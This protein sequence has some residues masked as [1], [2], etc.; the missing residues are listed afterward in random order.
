MEPQHQGLDRGEISGSQPD[1]HNKA[2]ADIDADECKDT[3]L[4]VAA[5]PDKEAGSR[6]ACGKADGCDQGRAVDILF[7][8]I[9]KKSGGHAE[10]KDGKAECPFGCAFG[11][12]NVFGDFLTENRPAVN[13]TDT[14]V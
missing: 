4:V 3:A 11:K 14:T 10:E 6:H 1:T 8:H 2:I 9:P 13:R 5:V 12:T 7:Y